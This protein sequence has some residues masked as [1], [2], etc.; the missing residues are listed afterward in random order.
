MIDFALL[1][2]YSWIAVPLVVAAV[3]IAKSV[4]NV[5]ADE[6]ATIERRYIG[7]TM[8]DGRTVSYNFV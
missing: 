4:L 1:I 5:K 7:K 6:L 2:A 8:K 3:L